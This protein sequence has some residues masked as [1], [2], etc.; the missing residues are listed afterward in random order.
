MT[1]LNQIYKCNV[2]GNMVEIVHT[3]AGQLVCCGKPMELNKANEQEASMEK[4]VPVV[5]AT[6]EGIRATVGSIKHPMEEKHYIEW[7]EVIDSGEVARKYLKPGDEP[8]A[9]FC[10]PGDN[11]E[12][13]AYC[14][15]HGLWHR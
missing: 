14:N 2:C 10:L 1:E 13:R 9:E 15:I 5:E 8:V 3:G 7:I 11:V 6:V 4:H 12:V